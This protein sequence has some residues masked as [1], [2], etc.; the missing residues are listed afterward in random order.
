MTP[1]LQ[2]LHFLPMVYRTQF[3]INLITYKCFIGQAPK[4]LS[5]LLLPRINYNTVSTRKDLDKTWLNC[6]SIE[7]LNYR[8]KGYRF[9]APVAWN[10]LDINIRESPTVETFR[11]RL[12]TFYYNQWLTT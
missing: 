1:F 10:L 12:K 9:S 6:H 11:K 2:K 7:K 5:T 4:Y 8:S 3:K